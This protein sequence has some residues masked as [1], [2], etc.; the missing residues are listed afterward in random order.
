MKK[1]RKCGYDAEKIN[2][3]SVLFDSIPPYHTFYAMI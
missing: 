3:L 1:G 2:S